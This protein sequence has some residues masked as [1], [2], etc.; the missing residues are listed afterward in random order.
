MAELEARIAHL[1][2]RQAAL[3]EE[4][5]AAGPDYVRL[6]SLSLALA[7]TTAE[8]DAALPRWLELAELTAAFEE[9]GTRR[10]PDTS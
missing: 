3:A 6:E 10:Q 4:V 1:E 7:E 5:S 8:I 9:A 2:A